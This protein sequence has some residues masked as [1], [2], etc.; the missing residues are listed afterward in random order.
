MK[1][2]TFRRLFLTSLVPVAALALA[3]A[4]RGDDAATPKAA[5]TV[6]LCD[7]QSTV[8]LQGLAPG[9]AL[10]PQ[11]ARRAAGEMLQAW[12]QTQSEAR[13]ASWAVEQSAALAKPAATQAPAASQEAQP[14]KF[15]AR[16]QMLWKREEKKFV[17]EGYAAYHNASTLGGTIGISCDMC[18]P[19]GSN[20]HPETYPKYQPQIKKVALLR[21]MINWCIE[22]PLKGKPLA[23]DDPRL[24]V[25]EAYIL[26]TRKGV[27]LEAGKH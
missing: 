11:E 23:E 6:S 26:S 17:D 12:R 14:T 2:R 20:T 16:D 21:D 25:V 15:T 1:P 13:W 10:A 19:D 27:P 4:L 3:P 18:H 22:N 24:R 8:T 9:Q 7:G 5:T